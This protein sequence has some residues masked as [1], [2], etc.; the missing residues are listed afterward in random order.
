MHNFLSS[1]FY[2]YINECG[3]Y[4]AVID[5]FVRE[6]IFLNSFHSLSMTLE[7]FIQY[8]TVNR[9]TNKQK[10][11]DEKENNLCYYN[12]TKQHISYV[13][14]FYKFFSQSVSN[15]LN[16]CFNRFLIKMLLNINGVFFRS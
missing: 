11:E 3:I 1:L 9:Q 5:F 10:N 12:N 6:Y 14:Y 2:I 4:Y 15:I 13:S 8:L 7:F 16:P